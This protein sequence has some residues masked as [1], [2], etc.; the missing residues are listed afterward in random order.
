M[1]VQ[2]IMQGTVKADGRLELDHRI[3]MPEGRVQ[4]TILPIP[5]PALAR[6]GRTILGVLDEIRAAQEA[7]GYGGRSIEEMEA[8]EAE[9]RAEEGEYE[10]RWRTLWSQ[11]TPTPPSEG[12][13]G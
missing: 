10:E 4:V 13:E 8:D 3:A 6:P 2:I 12:T 11:T 5:D 1:S 9:L 7:R